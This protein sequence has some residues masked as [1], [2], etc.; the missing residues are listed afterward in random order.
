LVHNEIAINFEGDMVISYVMNK[1]GMLQKKTANWYR[2]PWSAGITAN[3]SAATHV[4]TTQ[5]TP[6][7][8]MINAEVHAVATGVEPTVN[9]SRK[10]RARKI[11][12][13]PRVAGVAP[14]KKKKEPKPPRNPFRRSETVK[15]Q[16][17]RLQMTKRVETMKPRVDVMR[18][19]LDS[20]QQRLEFVSGK[21]KLV[22]EELV[23]R[24]NF[25][26]A[27][28]GVEENAMEEGMETV[29]FAIPLE[30]EA[31]D[32]DIELDDEVEPLAA[33]IE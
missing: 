8:E 32:E 21:L 30:E 7:V 2:T 18:E 33:D 25:G 27:V 24:A 16:L 5:T 29:D 17:K 6:I 19:R 12:D 28:E 31:A 4:A 11:K 26:K 3:E 13:G 23:S 20:M 14:A 1:I 9:A 15:L 10:G 22:V